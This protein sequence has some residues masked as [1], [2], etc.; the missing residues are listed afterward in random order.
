M[1]FGGDTVE[2]ILPPPPSLAAPGTQFW[3]HMILGRVE[4]TDTKTKWTKQELI[5]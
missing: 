4:G 3:T 2:P 1:I 5:Y